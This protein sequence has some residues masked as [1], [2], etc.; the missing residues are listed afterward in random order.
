VPL[1]GKSISKKQSEVRPYG[2]SLSWD[3]IPG[4]LFYTR[5]AL[6]QVIVSVDG[7]PALCTGLAC[8]YTYLV[9]DALITSF[10]IANDKQLT[11]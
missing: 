7:L 3:V 10:S 6:P 1:V 11:I 2:E 8:D 9:G 4:E 5:E